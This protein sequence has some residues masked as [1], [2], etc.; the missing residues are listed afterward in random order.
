MDG[1]YA[2]ALAEYEAGQI[3]EE[4]AA[5]AWV[6]ANGKEGDLKLEYVKIRAAQIENTRRKVRLGAALLSTWGMLVVPA[7][8]VVGV[9][10]VFLIISLI[11]SL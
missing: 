1:C 7:A 5:R 11:R 6:A 9:Y 4:L 3:D 8:L 2:T 10:C